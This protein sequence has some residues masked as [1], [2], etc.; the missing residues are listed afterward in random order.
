MP[1][2]FLLTYYSPLLP[3]LLF[4]VFFKKSKGIILWVIFLYSIYAFANDSVLIYIQ[5]SL[6][7]NPR[8]PEILFYGRFLLYSFTIIEYLFFTVFLYIII[9]NRFIKKIIIALSLAFTVF[10]VY[11]LFSDA[12]KKF[13]SIQASIEGILIIVFCIL[14]L[15]EQ[16]I[17]PQVLFIYTSYKFWIVFGI[18][19]YMAGNLFL[20]AYA[21]DLPNAM[22]KQYWIINYVSNIIK[23]IFFALAIFIQAKQLSEKPKVND[24]F[25][26]LI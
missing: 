22:R 9:E 7:K 26:N 23:N 21:V 1:L 3:V 12:T 25:R 10:C 6:A 24:P 19:I 17:K 13:D 20:F 15:Y 11:H 8:Q 16:M 2:S 14:Y 4:L 5:N 18:M